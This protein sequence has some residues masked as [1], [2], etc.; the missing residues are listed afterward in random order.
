METDGKNDDVIDKICNATFPLV[1]AGIRSSGTLPPSGE[2]FEFYQ[3]YPAFSVSLVQ[4]LC[5]FILWLRNF[6]LRISQNEVP[7]EY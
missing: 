6:I 2:S 3:S 7:N 5:N 1:T 4:L